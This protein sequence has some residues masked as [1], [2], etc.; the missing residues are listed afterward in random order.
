MTRY[1]LLLVV[2]LTTLSCSTAKWT[3]PTPQSNRPKRVEITVIGSDTASLTIHGDRRVMDLTYNSQG[4]ISTARYIYPLHTLSR[5]GGRPDSLSTIIDTSLLTADY[6]SFDGLSGEIRASLQS[7]T[8]ETVVETYLTMVNSKV[9]RSDSYIKSGVDTLYREV[10]NNYFD[11]DGYLTGSYNSFYFYNG[12]R[13]DFDREYYDD[14]EKFYGGIPTLEGNADFRL[15]SITRNN[16]T[17]SN[18]SISSLSTSITYPTD[19]NQVY[20]YHKEYTPSNVHNDGYFDLLY[21]LGS[22]DPWVN[23]YL[24]ASSVGRSRR[25]KYLPA[26]SKLYVD[27]EVVVDAKHH[28]T[29]DGRGRLH[30]IRTIVENLH[31]GTRV[32]YL[33]EFLY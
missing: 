32:E 21:N 5:E 14:A 2:L 13:S 8:A 1:R 28:Y 11:G 4:H 16:I 10:I 6:S 33:T 22:D 20:R 27:G 30:R 7:L 25:A 31:S 3:K 9:E 15:S 29:K 18:G 23:I 26:T 24:P 17:L 19:G 12:W